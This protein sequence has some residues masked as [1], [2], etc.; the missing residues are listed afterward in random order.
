MAARSDEN[1]RRLDVSM[2]D[3][4]RVRHIQSVGNFDGEIE[5]HL[6]LKRTAGDAMLQRRAF[7]ILHHDEGMAV[8]LRDLVNRSDVRMIQRGSG[9]RFAAKTFKSLRISGHLFRQEFSARRNGQA[10]CLRPCTPLPCL[11]LRASQGRGSG[12]WFCPEWERHPA[13]ALYITPGG[14]IRAIVIGP[15][16]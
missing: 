10:R 2:N 16:S 1:I 13:L 12:I 15:T 14:V 6:K 9:A 8:L 3:S 4:F 5:Q 7:Q 11:R